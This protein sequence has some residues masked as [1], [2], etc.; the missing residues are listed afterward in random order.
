MLAQPAR[1]GITGS[2]SGFVTDA[3]S[4][5]PLAGVHI[6]VEDTELSGTTDKK[7]Y[8]IINNIP[9]GIYDLRAEMIGYT[10]V[11]MQDVV[12]KTD[13]TTRIDFE[14]KLKAFAFLLDPNPEVVVTA[15]R[16]SATQEMLSSTFYIDHSRLTRQLPVDGYLD[17]FKFLPGIYR[18]H[19]RGGR[20][21]D[22][23]YLLDG[24]PIISPLTREVALSIPT[25]AISEIL[26]HTGGFSPEYGNAVAGVVNIISKRGRNNFIATGR[27]YTDDPAVLD[28]PTD[29]TRRLEIGFGGPM[30]V[31]FGGPVVEMN[32]FIAGDFSINGGPFHNQLS[33][34]FKDAARRNFNLFAVYDVKISR[35]VRLAFQGAYNAWRWRNI[36]TMFPFL[37][38]AAPLRKNRRSRMTF[39]L[40]HTL[41]P[42]MFY[43][44]TASYS[45]Y[46]DQ[47][48]GDAAADAP[49][50]VTS[51]A[52]TPAEAL[53][54][55]RAPWRQFS[56]ERIAYI[57]A[58]LLKQ[59][60]AK[61]QFKGGLQGEYY[62]LR[63][64]FSRYLTQQSDTDKQLYRHS[65]FVSRF[66]RFPRY[67]AGYFEFSYE[68]SRLQAKFGGRLDYFNANAPG[69][70]RPVQ[71]SL[72]V[73][74]KVSGKYTF[75]PRLS[76]RAMVSPRGRI[77][78]NY[79][80]Y[81]Q[82][83][84]LFYHYAGDGGGEETSPLW[85]LVGSAELRPT[86]SR[87]FELTYQHDF[88]RHTRF[89]AT[90]FW[91]KYSDLVN[92]GQFGVV[93]NNTSPENITT[94]YA[95][96]G[97]SRARGVEFEVFREWDS[98][99]RFRTVYTYQE[100]VGTSNRAEEAY[101]QFVNNGLMPTMQERPLNWDQRHTFI[102]ETHL[103]PW[104]GVFVSL[105][106]RLYTP[107]KWLQRTLSD[108]QS[109]K[110]P[111]RHLMDLKM[112][113]TVQAQGFRLQP[114]L[115]IRNLLNVHST[116]DTETF[117]LL[118]NQPLQPFEDFNGLR[119]RI[120]LQV[121]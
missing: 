62:D 77:S 42:T 35:N 85:P 36:D 107:R 27:T 8:F 20:A 116:E 100:V 55:E 79:G 90:A 106:N 81:A 61:L 2:I 23:I 11:R 44:I 6:L 65:R 32:Y 5:Q 26:V 47:V 10:P 1:A 114:F 59:I 112:G 89:S 92:T 49:D 18:N 45:K 19:F 86:T 102:F 111:W 60:T 21:R 87:H 31:S 46:T 57:D 110:L 56:T 24:V 73:R 113:Y 94:S 117:F 14:L 9:A 96:Q 84:P 67:T 101:F 99:L 15:R 16:V 93:Q 7:G 105:L 76:L 98:R 48:L 25:S 120:G 28:I 108:E 78:L 12:V 43:Y 3:N 103:K 69:S 38:P 104:R 66:S 13:L 51:R 91:R 40:T 88:D 72:S 95:N 29:R 37:P 39:R 58:S 34:Y 63:M 68:S 41:T 22:I 52:A 54:L 71:D 74:T 33:P 121:N 30:A 118:D 97:N 119:I 83:A 53:G 64:D 75:S 4:R 115:E 50:V 70:D 82:I 80:T 109:R 17:A